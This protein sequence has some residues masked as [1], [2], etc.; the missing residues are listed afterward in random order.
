MTIAVKYN[1]NL[2][3]QSEW[4]LLERDGQPSDLTGVTFRMHI[5]AR[6]NSPEILAI[7]SSDNGKIEIVSIT[8]TYQNESITGDG[9]KISLTA[10]DTLNMYQNA[11]NA[12]ADVEAT[13]PG[14]LIIPELANLLFEPNLSVT[15]DF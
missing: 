9:I 11:K 14:G 2:A 13:Y 5:R 12:V 7:A 8:T 4:L 10:E 15:R 6:I 3:W 1:P